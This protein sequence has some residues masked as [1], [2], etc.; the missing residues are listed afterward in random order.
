M[1]AERAKERTG[2]RLR[3]SRERGLE[4][5]RE[6]GIEP[7]LERGMER[8]RAEERGP[9]CHQAAWNFDVETAEWPSGLPERPTDPERLAEVGDRIIKCGTG[10]DLLDRAGHFA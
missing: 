9:H 5:G 8:G 2:R 6:Q 1:P 3:E 7:G 4:Q 10:A